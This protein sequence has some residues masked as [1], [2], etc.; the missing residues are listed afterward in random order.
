MKKQ[1]ILVAGAAVVLSGCNALRPKQTPVDVA[2]TDLMQ[3][4]KIETDIVA[5]YFD[6][7]GINFNLL[8][9]N[10]LSLDNKV[11]NELS[12]YPNPANDRINFDFGGHLYRTLSVDLVDLNGKTVRELQV[13]SNEDHVELPIEDLEN[14][15]YLIK[16]V[17]DD[18]ML[19]EK[20]TIQH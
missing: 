8:D 13:N 16:Y 17:I 15:L 6:T 3:R 2:F 4:P 9:S 5:E 12:V 1:V 7:I 11:V 18:K 19:I 20:I 10:T 14:G